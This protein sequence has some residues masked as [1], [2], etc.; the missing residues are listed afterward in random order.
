MSG[1]WDDI[2]F[3]KEFTRRRIMKDEGDVQSMINTITEKMV[4]SCEF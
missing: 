3:A 1:V 2:E 4:N